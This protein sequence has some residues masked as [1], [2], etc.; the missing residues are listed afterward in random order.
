MMRMVAEVAEGGHPGVHH[1]HDLPAGAAVS[2]RGDP[3]GGRAPHA[4]TRRLRRRRRR[5]PQR[6]EPGQRT[7]CPMIAT[8]QRRPWGAIAGAGARTGLQVAKGIDDGPV[9]DHFVVDV[10]PGADARAA[11]R[12]DPLSGSDRRAGGNPQAAEVV[13]DGHDPVSVINGDHQSAA[14][15]LPAGPRTTPA[16][17]AITLWPAAPRYE[18]PVVRAVVLGDHAA[19]DRPRQ[20]SRADHGCRL[21]VDGLRRGGGGGGW[22]RPAWA[23]ECRRGVRPGRGAPGGGQGSRDP[24]PG[25]SVP[26][27]VSSYAASA[28]WA[29][30]RRRTGNRAHVGVGGAFRSGP[31]PDGDGLCQE[32][33]DG[34]MGDRSCSRSL[35]GRAA[36]RPSLI[37]RYRSSRGCIP[38]LSGARP[39]SSPRYG[40]RRAESRARGWYQRR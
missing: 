2:R 3:R 23:V 7:R 39:R 38:R 16:A 34:D 29:T 26:R 24:G 37:G 31:H 9:D 32:G 14:V 21:N 11:H 15:V 5:R 25:R 30:A 35:V 13:V 28:P 20:L 22:R 6:S 1:Q 33:E 19:G 10:R 17:E 36:P 12:G 4:G 27:L 8:A 40:R 18:R